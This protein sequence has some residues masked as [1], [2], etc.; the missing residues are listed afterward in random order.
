MNLTAVISF[1]NNSQLMWSCQKNP[2]PLHEGSLEI[3]RVRGVLKG[4]EKHE[5]YRNTEDQ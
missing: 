4:K 5:A 3:L 2:Y 1:L